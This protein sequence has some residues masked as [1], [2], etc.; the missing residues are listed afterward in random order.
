MLL[1][2]GSSALKNIGTHWIMHLDE[3][4]QCAHKI[5]HWWGKETALKI[6]H[7]KR[8]IKG[9]TLMRER[10]RERKALEITR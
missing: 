10:E 5:G 3:D 1:E 7:W 6:V 2:R 4:Q 9:C 8:M